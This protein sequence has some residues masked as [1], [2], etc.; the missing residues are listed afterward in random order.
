MI[1]KSAVYAVA[2]L[3]CVL[4]WGATA[5]AA[6]KPHIITFGKWITVQ[7]LPLAG[8]EPSAM[9]L[10]PL[11]VDSRVKEFTLESP[12]EITER[13]F[14]V[15]RA[16]RLNDILPHEGGAPRWQ[17][18]RGGWILVDRVTGHVSPLNLPEFDMA[19]SDAIWY[20]DYAAYCGVS[21]DGKK[22]FAVVA[23]ISR[24]K[25]VLKKALDATSLAAATGN[26]AVEPACSAPTWQ[27]SPVRVTFEPSS[28]AQETFA[29]RG[30]IVDLMA[31]DD[32]T[33]EAA[34]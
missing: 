20:R 19:Y 29:I 17:W 3:S 22:I 11:L 33:E 4:L 14:V 7:W 23:Q 27:R 16:F 2:L 21:D 30:H 13:L 26:G 32:E 24:R 28:A 1:R 12:H 8:N 31:E 25:P 10:R 15:R 5:S 9:K 6:S 34:K 18:Q